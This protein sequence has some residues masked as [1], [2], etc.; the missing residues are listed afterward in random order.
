M[1][2]KTFGINLLRSISALALFAI[3]SAFMVLSGPLFDAWIRYLVE[4]AFGFNL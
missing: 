2:M 4:Q 1:K 3:F